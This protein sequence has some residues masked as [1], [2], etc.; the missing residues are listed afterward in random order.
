MSWS[1]SPAL[2]RTAGEGGERSEA[3]EGR[4][5]ALTLALA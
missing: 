4:P 3:D 2:R 5:L 1:P